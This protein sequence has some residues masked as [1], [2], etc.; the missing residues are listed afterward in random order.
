MQH[1]D[2]AK[3]YNEFVVKTSFPVFLLPPYD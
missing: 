3:F 2:V 1:N